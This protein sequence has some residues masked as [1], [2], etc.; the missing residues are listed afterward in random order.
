MPK[1]IHVEVFIRRS[2]GKG[3]SSEMYDKVVRKLVALLTRLG[4]RA[5]GTWRLG[6][7]P[8]VEDMFG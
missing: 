6:E 7:P 3:I 1:G 2:D 8:E 5:H 4:C